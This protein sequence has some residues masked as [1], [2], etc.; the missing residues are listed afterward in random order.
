MEGQFIIYLFNNYVVM[1]DVIVNGPDVIKPILFIVVI[2]VHDVIMAWTWFH[3]T[4]MDH[5]ENNK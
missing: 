2:M 3:N 4:I 1:T 5:N